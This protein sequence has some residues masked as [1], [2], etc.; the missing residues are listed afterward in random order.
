MEE[1]HFFTEHYGTIVVTAY[2]LV[3][4]MVIFFLAIPWK[5]QLLLLVVSVAVFILI[6][7]TGAPNEPPLG[8]GA[9]SEGIVR[10]RPKL[11]SEKPH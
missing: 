5:V 3:I 9:T 4:A 7:R 10:P 6:M 1:K 11:G 2:T 8:T